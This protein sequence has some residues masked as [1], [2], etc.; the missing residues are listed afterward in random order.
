MTAHQPVILSLLFSEKNKATEEQITAMLKPLGGHV[1]YADNDLARCTL[2]KSYSLS[3]VKA[4]CPALST[5][6]K[7][8]RVVQQLAPG[9]IK[10]AFFDMDST[11]I[12]QECID[13]MAYQCDIENGKTVDRNNPSPDTCFYKVRNIT[14]AAM[15]GSGADVPRTFEE[16]LRRRIN[17]LIEAGFKKEYLDKCYE[18][19]IPNPGAM[20]LISYLKSQGV[21]TVLVSGGFNFF[22]EKVAKR[23][24]MD[25]H[26]SNNLLFEG[27]KLKGVEGYP[28]IGIMGAEEKA[29]VMD[30][31]IEKYNLANPSACIS[32][33]NTAFTGDGSNDLL[34]LRKAGLG[35]AY[36]AMKP[37]L[38]DAAS[39]II[40]HG[41]L[42][43]L[44]QLQWATHLSKRRGPQNI[45]GAGK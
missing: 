43:S 20:Q 14:N 36:H 9:G 13:E 38:R 31:E 1:L 3:E 35:I 39:G 32:A 27:E 45:P 24:G 37:E 33:R 29:R 17:L 6:A 28:E 11:L 25:A 19:V 4:L 21:R 10:I 44:I 22:T 7:H 16:S 30:I 40:D 5:L 23:L 2:P 42:G 12:G 18:R 26:Y 15:H 34:G 8:D 41:N